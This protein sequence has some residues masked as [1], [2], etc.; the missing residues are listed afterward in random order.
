MD[1]RNKRRIFYLL[2]LLAII[3]Y[4]YSSKGKKED[5][6][7]PK[8]S[9]QETH[10]YHLG[11][12]PFSASKNL[13]RQDRK[14]Q[15]LPPNAYFEQQWE[16]TMNPSLGRPTPEV[17]VRLQQQ[18]ASQNLQ[19][20]SPGDAY[21]NAWEERGPN[22]IGGRTRAIL[23]DPNDANNANPADDYTLSLIHI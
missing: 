23:F 5:T 13:S 19:E 10:A 8:K 22:N 3:G 16:L 17:L 7:V 11:N 4:I 18:L 12:S 6:E 21:D 1:R 20:R 9:I 15:G 14:L 2:L